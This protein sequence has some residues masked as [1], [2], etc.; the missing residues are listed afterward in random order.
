MN[1]AV[2][3][4]KIVNVSEDTITVSVSK[5]GETKE[6]DIISAKIFGGIAEN[7]KKYCHAGDTVGVK[8]RL[9]QEDNKMYLLA[10]KVTF[11]SNNKDII[12]KKEEV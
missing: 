9:Q 3:V 7:T 1:Q 12:N 4:G 2:I 10:E 5:I 11:L 8:G 6:R